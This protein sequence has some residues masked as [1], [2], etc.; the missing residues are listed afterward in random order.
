MP[1][2]EHGSMFDGVLGRSRRRL[3]SMP[4]KTIL[5]RMPNWLGDAVMATPALENLLRHAADFRVV[6]AAP[7]LVAAMFRSNPAFHAVVVDRSKSVRPRLVGLYR[8][9]RDVRRAVGPVDQAV[10]LPNSLSS[11]LFLRWTGARRRVGAASPWRNILLTDAIAVDGAV[12][13]VQRYNRVINGLLGTD[14]QSGPLTLYLDQRHRFPRPTV[15][16]NPG[17]AYGSAKR[18]A[19]ERFGEV[20]ADLARTHDVVILGAEKEKEIA[21][22]VEGVLRRNAVANYQNLAGRTTIEDLIA[23]IGGLALLVTNDSG[24]M[25]IAAALGVP[26]VVVFGPTD[27]VQTGPWRHRRCVIVRHEV[28]CAPCMKRV[29]PLDYHACMQE[30]QS[31]QVLKAARQLLEEG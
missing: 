22:Q 1:A 9:G 4:S 13:Q 16:I 17:A 12:H 31:G 18:W 6:L 7:R 28:P 20:A 11:A 21:D 3:E 27:H 15:G 24:P 23:K 14:C 8:A 10:A 2:R 26:C 19:A 5:V 25:H 30:V 29:C